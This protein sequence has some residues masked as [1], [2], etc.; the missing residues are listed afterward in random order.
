[1]TRNIQT[2]AKAPEKHPFPA[3]VLEALVVAAIYVVWMI[4]SLMMH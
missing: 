3:S 2:S 4:V 1:M